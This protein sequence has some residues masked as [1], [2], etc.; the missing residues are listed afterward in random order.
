MKKKKIWIMKKVIRGCLVEV[1]ELFEGGNEVGVLVW[2]GGTGVFRTVERRKKEI[3]RVIKEE[4]LNQYLPASLRLHK[5]GG[6]C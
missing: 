1:V 6:E 5:E 2:S 4:V 3:V